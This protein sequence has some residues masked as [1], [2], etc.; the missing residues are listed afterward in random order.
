V[1]DN[2]RPIQYLFADFDSLET[3]LPIKRTI[4]CVFD[5]VT[6]GKYWVK[7]VWDKEKPFAKRDANFYRPEKGDYENL[8]SPIIEVKAGK[9]IDAGTIKCKHK[10]NGK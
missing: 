6:P 8:V 3:D 5:G 10:V 7:A 4:R 9:R 1:W 2:K